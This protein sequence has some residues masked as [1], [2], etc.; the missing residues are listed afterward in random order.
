MKEQPNSESAHDSSQKTEHIN[1]RVSTEL[2]Q[3]MERAAKHDKRSPSD[4]MRVRLQELLIQK[5]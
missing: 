3:L 1:I 2:K 5:K 4:W